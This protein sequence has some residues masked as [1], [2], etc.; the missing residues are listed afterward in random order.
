VHFQLA[1]LQARAM[2]SGATAALV[3]P[4]GHLTEGTSGNLFCVERGALLTPTTRNILPGI[5]RDVVLSLARKLAIPAYETDIT[6]AR[7][8]A[9]E[10]MFV[11]STSIGILHARS[12]ERA[13]LGDGKLGAVTARLRVALYEELQIDIAAQAAAYAGRH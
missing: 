5:T 10:E 12:F 6:P 7:A 3:D 9:C 1:N 11:T 8:S 13:T 4:D 2:L